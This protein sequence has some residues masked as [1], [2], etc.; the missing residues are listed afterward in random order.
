LCTTANFFG[1]TSCN[2]ACSTT[3]KNWNPRSQKTYKTPMVIL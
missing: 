2:R 1:N 3:D